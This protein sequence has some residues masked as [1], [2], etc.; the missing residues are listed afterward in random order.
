MAVFLIIA[1]AL[2]LISYIIGSYFV[3]Y[4]I[5]RKERLSE[6]FNPEGGSSGNTM[7]EENRKRLEEEAEIFMDNSKCMISYIESEDGLKL[8]GWYYPNNGSRKCVILVHGYMGDHGNMM[9]LA[10]KYHSWGYSVLLP[11]NRAHGES[12]GKYIGMGWLDRRDISRWMDWL[13][14]VIDEPEIILHG[15]SMGA[16]TVMMA[17]GDNHPALKAVVEDCGYTSVWDIFADELKVLFHLPAFPLMDFCSGVMKLKA[18]YSAK[19]ASSIKQL[20]KTDIPMLFIHGTEDRFVA[21]RMLDI[22]YNAKSR[23]YREKL[24]IP[25]ARHAESEYT[26][27]EKYYGTVKAFLEKVL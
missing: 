11:D 25:G 18:G 19:E 20:S 26:D 24:E 13:S 6:S 21:F 14:T 1:A 23:G 3:N 12:E 7:Y 27:P 9:T 8:K 4:A 17:A 10:A 15:V 5:L 2:L 22:N 16:A